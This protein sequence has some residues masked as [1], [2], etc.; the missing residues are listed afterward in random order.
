MADMMEERPIQKKFGLWHKQIAAWKEK[1]PFGYRVTEEVVKSQHMQD[2][3][4]ARKTKSFCR[5]CD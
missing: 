1:A 3:L 4:K 2:H 5:R